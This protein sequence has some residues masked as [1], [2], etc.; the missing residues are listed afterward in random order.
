MEG[1]GVGSQEGLLVGILDGANVVGEI[2]IIDGI[3]DGTLVGRLSIVGEDE[4][5]GSDDGI[6]VGMISNGERNGAALDKAE[7]DM[8]G[9]VVGLC[10]GLLLG[11]TEGKEEDEATEGFEVEMSFVEGHEVGRFEDARPGST[12]GSR[13]GNVVGRCDGIR[14]GEP[15]GGNAIGETDS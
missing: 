15:L 6:V 2:D 11:D 8:E 4:T 5:D 12:E 9:L 14:G 13:V 1:S 3:D 7:S 10:V